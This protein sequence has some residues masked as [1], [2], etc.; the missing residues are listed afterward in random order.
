MSD[1][2]VTD[3]ELVRITTDVGEILGVDSQDYC[4]R[5]GDIV[6]LPAVNATPLVEKGAA[7]RLTRFDPATTD[8]TSQSVVAEAEVVAGFEPPK[9]RPTPATRRLKTQRKAS[10]CGRRRNNA[11]WQRA[12]VSSLRPSAPPG[13]A[14]QPSASSRTMSAGRF[15]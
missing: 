9:R 12:S 2:G 11:G 15:G 5:E 1:A 13:P 7:V 4:L 6:R 14:T 10:R 8:A 3:E